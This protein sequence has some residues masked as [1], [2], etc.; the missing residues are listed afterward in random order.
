[1]TESYPTLPQVIGANVQRLRGHHTL[2]DVASQGRSLGAR[3]S[4]GS[5]HAIEKGTFKPTLDTLAILCQALG[6][7]GLREGNKR[8]TPTLADLLTSPSPIELSGLLWTDTASL[9]QWLQG[10]NL[11]TWVSPPALEELQNRANQEVERVKSLN[12][13]EG[14]VIDTG[15]FSAPTPGEL[16]L[17]DRAGV[18]PLELQVWAHHLWNQPIEERRDQV[19]GAGATAQKKGRV[20][21]L[22]LDE[23]TTAMNRDNGDD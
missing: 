5:I 17:S 2:A 21:R 11:D 7:L 1:M 14:W 16:R 22:L 9:I 19:A 8:P 18:D 4:S 15:K 23:L 13:P 20:S 12:F 6:S 3:W 10:G